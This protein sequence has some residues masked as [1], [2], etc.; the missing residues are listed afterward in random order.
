MHEDTIQLRLGRFVY[1]QTMHAR[2]KH[3]QTKKTVNESC[4]L[5]IK[6]SSSKLIESQLNG[7]TFKV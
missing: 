4:R 1:T 5:V 7:K 2:K 3:K 6:T